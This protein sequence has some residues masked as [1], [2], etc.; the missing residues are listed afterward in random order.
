MVGWVYRVITDPE[1][2]AWVI[3]SALGEERYAI[4]T[5]FHRER[6]YYPDVALV[7]LAWADQVVLIDPLALDLTPLAKLLDSDATCVLHAASQD[8]EVLELATGSV[9]R[10][11]FD[12]QIGAGFLGIATG[13]LPLLLRTFLDVEMA[14]GDRL[15]DWLRRP[16]SD[17]QLRYAAADVEHLLALTDV[18]YAQLTE[19][20][21]LEWAQE[22]STRL[23]ERP[24]GPRT[25][26]DALRRIK[27]A[28]KLKGR[29]LRVARSLA[30][31]RDQR[32]ARLNVPVRQVMPDIGVV[33]VAQRSPGSHRDLEGLRGVDGRHLKA[34]VADELI[35][36]VADGLA[37]TSSATTT[38]P[39]PE[40]AKNLRPA[41]SLITS[42]VAQVA[43]DERMDPA[44]IA[45][46]ADIEALLSDPPGGRL[47]SGWRG[48]LV[49]EPIRKLVGGDAALAFENGELCLEP[50]N[51][52]AG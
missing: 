15:T 16:L 40:L 43:R 32:A 42:W 13:S 9:P 44:L 6:T 28:R 26:E 23:L 47:S 11:L 45:T 1:D 12:T 25:A 41:V 29:S 34:G 52:T 38:K 27:D 49:G 19:L 21:R 51:V 31:W 33:A 10:V 8:L 36:A 4:D 30:L 14:K 5:E 7:Q 18:L 50:R 2:F 22:E 39:R 46:R 3:D 35:A 17:D 24:R 37:D 20:G 48:N